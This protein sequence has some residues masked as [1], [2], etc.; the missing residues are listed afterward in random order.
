[1]FVSAK[2]KKRTVHCQVLWNSNG[3][4]RSYVRVVIG[5]MIDG[6]EEGAGIIT[7]IPSFD[8]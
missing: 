4:E 7:L 8:A 3:Q 2:H 5:E 1:M 6:L